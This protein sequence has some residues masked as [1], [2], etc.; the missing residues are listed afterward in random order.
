MS[1]HFTPF[2][3]TYFTRYVT[4]E[5]FHSKVY[6]ERLSVICFIITENPPGIWVYII[7]RKLWT[8]DCCC[9]YYCAKNPIISDTLNVCCNTKI[10]LLWIQPHLWFNNCSLYMRLN[11]LLHVDSGYTRIITI[12]KIQLRACLVSSVVRCDPA[13]SLTEY[14]LLD[15]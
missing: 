7:T 4:A 13:I 14:V 9:H 1:P 6:L 15:Y 8:F 10:I 2:K 11:N 3:S 12:M 5:A